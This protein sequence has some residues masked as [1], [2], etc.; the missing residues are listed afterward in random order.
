MP[1][2][3]PPVEVLLMMQV[4][5]APGSG[6]SVKPACSGALYGSSACTLAASVQ[7]SV[8]VYFVMSTPGPGASVM[9]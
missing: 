6:V 9:V 5:C 8:A 7:V 3:P 2:P 4:S 1:I